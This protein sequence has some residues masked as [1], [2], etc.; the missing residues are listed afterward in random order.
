MG[1]YL[2]LVGALILAAVGIY[3]IVSGITLKGESASKSASL[4][5]VLSVSIF[6]DLALLPIIFAAVMLPIIEI[7]LILILFAA[8]SAVSLTITVY[9]AHLGLAKGVERLPPRYMDYVM[10]ATLL[11]TAAIIRLV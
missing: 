8:V 6:P 2:S 4:G 3:F 7:S 5:A 10:G 9:A 11:I 1:S